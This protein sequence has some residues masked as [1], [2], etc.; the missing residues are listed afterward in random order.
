MAAADFSRRHVIR[1]TVSL[2]GAKRDLPR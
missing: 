2:S 1:R